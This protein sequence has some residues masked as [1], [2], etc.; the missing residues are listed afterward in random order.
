MTTPRHHLPLALLANYVAGNTNEAVSLVVACHVTL[1]AACAAE[2]ARLERAAGVQLAAAAPANVADDLLA[3]TLARLDETP[4]A[5][6]TPPRT[7]L[8]DAPLPAPLLRVLDGAPTRTD[9]SPRWRRLTPGIEQIPL[10]VATPGATAR[11]LRLAPNV[12]VPLHGHEGDELVAVF[13]GGLED[14]DQVFERGDVELRGA[15]DQHVQRIRPGAPC[16]ALV[17]NHGRLVPRTWAGRLF[18]LITGV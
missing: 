13:S 9:G 1:C 15:S 4:A 7:Q 12:T 17:V 2:H 3:R 16:I 10:P 5:A 8:P 14:G 11:L 18:A 6:P